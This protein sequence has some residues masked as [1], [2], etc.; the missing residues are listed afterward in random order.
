M[1]FNILGPM[2]VLHDGHSCTPTAPKVRRVLALLLLRANQIVDT[3]ALIDELWF[4]NPPRSAVTT[5]QTY[6]YQLRKI[7]ARMMPEDE[8][9][10]VLLTQAPGYGLALT[11]DQLD[12]KMF[13]RLS[14]EGRALAEDGRLGEASKRLNEALRLWRGRALA[15][16]IAG[17]VLEAHVVHLEE[18]RIRTLELR[19]RT[20]LQL[21]KHR[22]LVP[23]LRSLV[24]Q[25]P[26]NEWFHAQLITVLQRTGRRCEALQV[27]QDLRRSLDTELGLEPSIPLR[28]L[29]RELLNGEDEHL[30][31][32]TTLATSGLAVAL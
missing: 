13:E 21:G 26:L 5:T 2:E 17:S 20:D 23:E 9:A 31:D 29:Q 12:V 19:V 18:M 11:D 32:V 24:S 3:E 1:R 22:E 25:H 27:Y 6:I 10:R 30:S 7:F 14:E 4:D 15:D 16:V 28:R 8:A